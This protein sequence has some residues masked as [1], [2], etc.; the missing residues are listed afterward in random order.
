MCIVEGY[1]Q[2]TCG[3][4]KSGLGLIYGGSAVNKG[5]WPWVATLFLK[6]SNQIFCAGNLISNQHLLTG[7]RNF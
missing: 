3:K 5:E 2:E 6:D 1:S 4:Q 7:I